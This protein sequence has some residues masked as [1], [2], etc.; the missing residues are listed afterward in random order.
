[1]QAGTTGG[2]IAVCPSCCVAAFETGGAEEI[3]QAST[4]RSDICNKNCP[5]LFMKAKRA[6]ML[7]IDKEGGRLSSSSN[8]VRALSRPLIAFALR[9]AATAIPTYPV[10]AFLSVRTAGTT[11]GEAGSSA[12]ASAC[13]RASLI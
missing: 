4:A 2:S 7:T 8:Q 11:T 3:P 6:R 1:M 12:L 10:A 13:S 9:T 5:R